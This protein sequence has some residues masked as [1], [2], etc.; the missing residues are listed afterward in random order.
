[1]QNEPIKAK[2]SGPAR[3]ILVDDHPLVRERLAELIR[4]EP[5]LVVCG[6]ADDHVPALTLIA[7]TQPDLVIVDLTLKSSNGID[8]IRDVHARWPHIL[9]LVLSMHDEEL[10]A[11][12]VIRAGA[13]GYVTKQ[14]ATGRILLAMRAVLRGEI[15]L[16]GKMTAEI[17]AKTI[18]FPRAKP[19]LAM[20]R[21]SQRELLVFQLIGQGMGTREIADALDLEV[22]TIETYRAR[23]KEKFNFKDG[24]E[25]LQHAI[26]WVQGGAR[27]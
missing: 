13:Q 19:G 6:E 25:L 5:D 3:V 16:S 7:A 8:L 22:R 14:E 24:N 27:L 20:D 4:R 1:M 21:L 18:H 26:R 23:I 12:R 17:A 15:Y 9:M 10:Q 2:A 11:E